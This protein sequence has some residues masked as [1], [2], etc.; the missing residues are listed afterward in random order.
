MLQGVMGR[1]AVHSVVNICVHLNAD[2]KSPP[3]SEIQLSGWSS[4]LW[5]K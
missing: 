5:G 4:H 2:P 1:G 3:P